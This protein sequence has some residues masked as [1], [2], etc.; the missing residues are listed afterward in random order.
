MRLWIA[1][2]GLKPNPKCKG[3]RRFDGGEGAHVHITAWAESREAFASLR[4]VPYMDER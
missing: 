3:F 2:A 1:P 4:N